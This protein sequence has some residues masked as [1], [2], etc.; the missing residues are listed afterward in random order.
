MLFNKMRLQALFSKL[1]KRISTHELI[2]S[3]VW[4]FLIFIV[5]PFGEFYV[6]DDWFYTINAQA[7]ALDNAIVFHDWGA[8]TLF[9]H[10]IWGTLFCKI[11]GLSF[12]VLRLCTLVLSLVCLLPFYRLCLTAHFSKQWAL[13]DTSVL[14]FNQFFFQNAF[15]YMT[16]VPFLTFLILS[17]IHSL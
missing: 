12:T 17:S 4:V 16:E 13:A 9:A 3:A 14:A 6:N 5:N 11:F 10:K 15:S 1:S 2:I 8:M 7:M